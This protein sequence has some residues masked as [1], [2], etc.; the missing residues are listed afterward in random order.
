MSSRH[1]DNQLP[2]PEIINVNQKKKN[3][4]A[5]LYLNPRQQLKAS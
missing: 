4:E 1:F 5:F 2:V 3:K